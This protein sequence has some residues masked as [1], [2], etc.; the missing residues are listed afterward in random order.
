MMS[1]A[2][3]QMMVIL[4][5]AL[6]ITLSVTP[7][8]RRFA[9]AMGALDRPNRR[10]IH[11]QPIPRLGG[12][13]VLAGWAGALAFGMGVAGVEG[14]PGPLVPMMALGV[15]V[16]LFG[17]WDDWSDL[18]GRGK[19]AAQIL[20]ASL[21][22]L[23]GI[24]IDRITNPFGG[25]LLFPEPLSYA[26][27]VF[28]VIGMMNAVN[29]ID[30]LDGLACG[31]AAITA[32]GLMAAG[33]FVRSDTSVVVLAALAGACL[34]FL[35]YNFH[36]ATI[37][38]GDSGSQFLGFVLA[39]TPLLDNQYKS[40]TVVA[41]LLPLTALSLPIFD[42]ALAFVRRLRKRRSI[43]RAD[44]AHLHH[45]L[46]KL[47]L[48]QRQVVAAFYLGSL[49]L[50]V[51]AFLFV[52]IPE[53]YA[54]ILLGLLALGLMMGIQTLRFVEYKFLQSTRARLRRLRV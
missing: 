15:L 52:L 22:F 11:R 19:L 39:M 26:V 36:P 41:L 18:P 25:V 3:G 7:W 35:R 27:T 32:G 37:F 29:L 49:Y 44:K 45:R 53:R 50:S 14:T 20:I 40:A 24:R 33:L 9:V 48:S 2:A 5:V 46:L 34:G 28:W 42:T 8:V 17:A 31:I 54:V 21:V 30:G 1:G 38:L 13:A 12:V 23:L 4:A 43:F 6:L 10:K 51:L 16:V 47:G